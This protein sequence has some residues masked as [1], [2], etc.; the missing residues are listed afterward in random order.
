MSEADTE[1]R[2]FAALPAPESEETPSREAR[3]RWLELPEAIGIF[4]LTLIAALCGGLIAVYW[5]WSGNDASATAD[6][7]AA[8]ETRVAQISTSRVAPGP[9]KALDALKARLDADETRLAALEQSATSVAPAAQISA[10]PTNDA[11]GARVAKL[12]ADSLGIK[13]EL[14]T[15]ALKSDE[16]ALS[17][18]IAWLESRD[19]GALLKR[20]GALMALTGIERASLDGRPF[21]EE[22]ANLRATAPALPEIATLAR[23][24]ASGV[25][26]RESLKVQLTGEAAGI[27][28]ADRDAHAKNWAQRLWL[29]IADLVSIRRVGR[30]KGR[31]TEAIVARAEAAAGSGDIEQALKEMN[32]L[33]APARQAAG[34]WIAAAD[35]RVALD[36]AIARL[37]AQVLALMTAPLPATTPPV[38]TPPIATVPP[39]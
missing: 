10:M 23:Y 9:S 27:I 19:P 31:S 12:E 34:T 7:L 39:R 32:A 36:E 4:A 20:A 14:G 13:Q 25:A 28:E 21:T 26:T 17:A 35:A 3:G 38:T 15:A 5:P 11:L 1:K 8:L 33:D 2:A 24:A 16:A 30:T 29:H 22:L 18:R 6:R 37:S